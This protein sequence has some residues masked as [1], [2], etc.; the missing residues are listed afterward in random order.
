MVSST[1]G[2]EAWSMLLRYATEQA[3]RGRLLLYIEL[4]STDPRVPLLRNC[5]FEVKGERQIDLTRYGGEGEFKKIGMVKEPK[6]A[7]KEE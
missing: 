7:V 3:D 4:E 6:Q 5:G 2:V 1:N